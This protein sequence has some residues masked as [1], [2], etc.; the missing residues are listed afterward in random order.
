M[1]EGVLSTP[2]L[3]QNRESGRMKRV[4]GQLYTEKR[5]V[6]WGSEARG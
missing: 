3:K 6:A 4:R 1:K 2:E 5:K